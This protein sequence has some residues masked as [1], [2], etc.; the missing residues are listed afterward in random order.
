MGG[1]PMIDHEL[2]SRVIADVPVVLVLL[3]TNWQLWRRLGRIEDSLIEHLESH[4][5]DK[6]NK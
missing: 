6:K 2:L 1:L 3:A 4:H 5:D